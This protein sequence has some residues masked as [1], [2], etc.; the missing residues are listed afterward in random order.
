M[1]SHIGNKPIFVDANTDVRSVKE[2][3][4][5]RSYNVAIFDTSIS[6][7]MNLEDF[8]EAL[9]DSESSTYIS[10]EELLDLYSKLSKSLMPG[11]KIT[12]V[13]HSTG[14]GIALRLKRAVFDA[15]ASGVVPKENI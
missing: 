11:T 9:W 6:N 14:A 12:V 4:H 7:T 8:D 5:N 13:G 10:D 3:D 15:Y 1:S 2:S